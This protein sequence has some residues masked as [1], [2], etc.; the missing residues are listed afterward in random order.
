MALCRVLVRSLRSVRGSIFARLLVFERLF[1][2]YRKLWIEARI[3][4][5]LFRAIQAM[6]LRVGVCV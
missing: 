4:A 6:L 2:F 3:P 1:V 5:S